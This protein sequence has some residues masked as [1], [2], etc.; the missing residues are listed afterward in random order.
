[1]HGSAWPPPRLEVPGLLLRRW[2]Q[3]DAELLQDAVSESHERL[4]EWMPWAREAPSLEKQRAYLQTAVRT[5]AD[6]V[7]YGY[8]MFDPGET[9]VLGSV[10]MHARLGPGALE[11]GYWVH[12]AHTRR[13][14]ASTATALV[15]DVAFA[16][17]GIERTEIH[18]DPANIASAG[19]PRVL[20]Y[21]LDRVQDRDP[22]LFGEPGREMVWVMS[23]DAYK[24]SEAWRRAHAHRV[25]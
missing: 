5:W 13:G 23:R 10:A 24:G 19:V 14:L 25:R 22:A 4:R 17:P 16:L 15:T 21:R 6:G 1:M 2:S 18:C 3:D 12:S 9:A 20:G 11:I 8:G 7:D